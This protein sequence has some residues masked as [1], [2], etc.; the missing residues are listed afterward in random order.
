MDP[1]FWTWVVV[2]LMGL[3]V[4]NGKPAMAAVFAGPGLSTWGISCDDIG[5]AAGSTLTDAVL[6]LEGV[7]RSSP[8][9]ELQITL[10]RNPALGF[11]NASFP[12]TDEIVLTTLPAGDTKDRIVIFFSG[13][14]DPQSP[15]WKI[16]RRPFVMPQADGSKMEYSSATLELMDILGTEKSFGLGFRMEAEGSVQV[17]RISL[18]LSVLPFRGTGQPLARTYSLIQEEFD[19]PGL[20]GWSIVDQGTL[21]A[22]SAWTVADGWLRQANNTCQQN[23][24]AS[25]VD[26]LGTF[27][28]CRASRGLADFQLA[29]D[30]RSEDDDAI[31][32]MFRY[33]DPENYYRF[34]WDQQRRIRRLVKCSDGQFTVLAHDAVW[35]EIGKT[36]R[37]AI[38][39]RGPQFA[40]AID[41]IPIFY[42]FDNQI[43]QGA[44][45]LYCCAQQGAVFDNLRI[46]AA[47]NRTY[48][49]MAPI[50]DLAGITG[51]PMRIPIAPAIPIPSVRYWAD[52]PVTG[53]VFDNGQLRWTPTP[54]QVG[55]HR[56]GILAEGEDGFDSQT[57]RIQVKAAGHPPRLEPIADQTVTE[58]HTLIVIPM[59]TDPDGG[60]IRYSCIH[61]PP[62]AIFSD[63]RFLWT[64][65]LGQ[66]G[67][68]WILLLATD[69]IDGD[70]MRVK[71]TVVPDR[72]PVFGPI[73][74]AVV[75]E[76]TTMDLVV[77]VSDPDGDA[78]VLR[79]DN[80]P[81]GVRLE[82]GRLSW[83][84]DYSQ[85]GQYSL[86]IVAFDGL[87]ESRAAVPITVLN[88]NR[89][90]VIGQLPSTQS[91][92]IGRYLS[93]RIQAVDP[94]GDAVQISCPNLPPGATLDG[95]TLTWM[96]G[97]YQTGIF[98]IEI[99]AGDGVSSQSKVIVIRVS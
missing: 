15:V 9:A 12:Q 43:Q 28:V 4:C 7:R 99:V 16:F 69:G 26:M 3:M 96:P 18:Q 1:G 79:L 68:Q 25:A 46:E 92:M 47:T 56:V 33:R 50:G 58:G 75:S 10:L 30:I 37:V 53:A 13:I 32:V 21:Y 72:P 65:T 74:P 86:T 70:I 51:E 23:L 39:A 41:G 29:V 89:P 38:V 48:R 66:A 57:A 90:P 24:Q 55:L 36:Y 93:I 54:S 49:L 62:G 40:V 22:P 8:S 27:A 14:D 95:N 5:I 77:P 64:P 83:T 88:T 17:D 91:L 78:V 97:T 42:A 73:T 61:L 76:G 59:A 20:A 80:P 71:I 94:D 67:E 35:Y 19:A 85:A 52:P 87:L 82:N 34:S 11:Q 44:I 31:G 84:P 81:A 98:E 45:G 63:N 6:V 60:P 2:G